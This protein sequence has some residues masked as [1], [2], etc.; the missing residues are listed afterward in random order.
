[1][2]ISE[3]LNNMCDK[4]KIIFSGGKK[5]EGFAIN[6]YFRFLIVILENTNE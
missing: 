1:M 5:N 2:S 3:V 4:Y 6:Y